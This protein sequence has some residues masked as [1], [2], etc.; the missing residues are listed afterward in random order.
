[1]GKKLK[2]FAI[3]LEEKLF[4]QFEQYVRLNR[5]GNRSQFIRDLIRKFLLQQTWKTGKEIVVVVTLV[6]SHHE[7]DL[8]GRLTEFQH[9][10]QRMIVSTTHIH[11]DHDNCLEVVIVRGKSD[12]VRALTERLISLR[13][14]KTGSVSAAGSGGDME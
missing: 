14:I 10:H 6:Y 3:S 12:K 5:G 7:G 13:G 11:L 2:R 4:N 8:V 9:S 1:M